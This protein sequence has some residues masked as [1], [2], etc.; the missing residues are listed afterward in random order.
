[1]A[2]K[3]P[4]RDPRDLS[5]YTFEWTDFIEDGVI[6]D[7]T[8]E[9]VDGGD[10]LEI[11]GKLV[12]SKTVTVSDALAQN[13]VRWSDPPT[14][15]TTGLEYTLSV[16]VANAGRDPLVWSAVK[17]LTFMKDL[18]DRGLASLD[19][20]RGAARRMFGQGESAFYFDAPVASAF[21]SR[22]SNSA[23]WPTSAAIATTSQP[24]V[25]FSHG[26]M[27]DVSSPPE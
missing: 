17:T 2:L 27:M 14:S 16:R 11:T 7:A 26:M 1:M 4:V 6:A 24:Y 3:F 5:D 12:G 9:V 15:L 10:D 23:F 19:V 13:E 22:P 20:D 8:V 18:V 21:S 25:S